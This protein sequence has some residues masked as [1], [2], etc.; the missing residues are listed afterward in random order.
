MQQAAG[1]AGGTAV[2]NEQR[3]LMSGTLRAP[4]TLGGEKL[5]AGTWFEMMGDTLYR[6]KSASKPL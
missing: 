1:R 2:F 6:K 5:E 4:A 3:A